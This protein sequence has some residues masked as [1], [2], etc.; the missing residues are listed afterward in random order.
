MKQ[1][2]NAKPKGIRQFWTSLGH[3]IDGIIYAFTVEQNMFLHT[4][5]M[6]IVIGCGIFFEISVVEWL[7][8]LIM[9]GLVLATELINTSIEAVVDLI[10]KDYH[11]LAK[12]AKDTAAGAV[13]VFAL[14]AAAGGM[15][16]F[17]PKFIVFFEGMI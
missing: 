9:F 1:I 17:L 7:F 16:I 5:V 11:V 12:V 3:A 4:M 2:S 6:I 13:L 15:I 14:T 8:C 10:T